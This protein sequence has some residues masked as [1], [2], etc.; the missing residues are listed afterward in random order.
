MPNA[1]DMYRAQ[2]TAANEV[3]AKLSEVAALVLR[4]RVEVNAL[5]QDHRIQEMLRQE[6]TWLEQAERTVNEVRRWRDLEA[7]R[8]WPGVV[9]R[10]T[11][12]LAFALCA[13]WVSGAGYSWMQ[14]D[15]DSEVAVLRARVQTLDTIE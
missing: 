2:Q 10:W 5:T 1:L 15:A 3:H 11:I 7:H 14:H 8:F 6:Q 12:A 9:Y 4:V 13:L